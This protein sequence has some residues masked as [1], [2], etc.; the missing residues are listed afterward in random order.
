MSSIK[1]LLVKTQLE[2]IDAKVLLAHLVE[3]YLQWPKSALISK[4]TDALPENLL[5]EWQSLESRRLAGEPVAYILEKKEF[6][7]IELKV[8]PGVLIPRPET[9]LLVELVIQHIQKKSYESPRI[10]DLGTGS[11]AIALALATNIPKA[12]VTAVDIS[13]EALSIAEHNAHLLK[14]EQQLHFYQGSWF[15]ALPKTKETSL[16]DVIVSNPPYIKAQDPHLNAGDLRFEPPGALT[17]HFDGLNAYRAIFNQAK[18]FLNHNGMLIVEHGY[19]QSEKVL[20]L[21]QKLSY[22]NIQIH[23]DLAGIARAASAKLS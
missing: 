5:A 8:A 1:E 18:A 10:L 3:K 14:L 17:D 16:F 12:Q 4:D 11:G 21:L 20:E 19:D 22:S 7:N 23:Y 2:K 13:P 6:F 9:E 15:E